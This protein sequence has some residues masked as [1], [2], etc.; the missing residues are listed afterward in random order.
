VT[1]DFTATPTVGVVTPAAGTGPPP[2]GPAA[3]APGEL[4]AGR[5]RIARLLGA[6]GAGQVFEAIDLEIDQPLALKVLHPRFAGDDR[7]T[8]HFK[9]EFLLARR[10]THPNV[11]RVFDLFTHRP[12]APG[13]WGE[14]VVFLTMELLAGETLASRLH[15]RGRLAPEEV[16]PL[17]EQVAR[18]LDAAHAAGV[19]HRDFKSA[20]VMLIPAA[21]EPRAV[22]TDFGVAVARPGDPLWVHGNRGM[23]GSPA[24]MAPEQVLGAEVTAAADI[25]A[26]GVVLYELVTGRRPFGGPDR[27]AAALQRLT[28]PPMPPRRLLPE[29]DRRWEE[30]ILR[31]LEREPASRF[32]SAGEAIA[33]L[34]ADDPQRAA[35]V[36]RP[37]LAVPGLD[38]LAPRPETGWLAAAL[39]TS[40]ASLPATPEAARL[41]A[42]GLEAL[43]R[44]EAAAARDLLEQAVALDPNFPLAHMALS[45]AWSAVGCDATA[46]QAASRA[47]ELAVRL[48]REQRLLVEARYWEAM[49]GWERAAE[50]YRALATFFPDEPAY[51]LR[52]AAVQTQNGRA[53]DALA[54][55]DGLRALAAPA[56]DD[57]RIDL[58]EARAAEALSEFGRQL[59]AAETAMAKARALGLPLLEAAAHLL[60]GEARQHSGDL[61]GALTA[62][63]AAERI[64]RAAGDLRGTAQAVRL[65]G[66]VLYERRDLAGAA[67]RHEEGLALARRIGNRKAIGDALNKIG[68]VRLLQGRF[69]EA[70]RTYEEALAIRREIADLRGIANLE[71]N[72]GLIHHYRSDLRGARPWYEA[73]LA[74]FTRCGDR[75]E[76]GRVLY[77]LAD[78]LHN[79]G[80]LLAARAV[81]EQAL[82]LFWLIGETGERKRVV[83]LIASGLFEGGDLRRAAHLLDLAQ[84]LPDLGGPLVATAVLHLR[85]RLLFAADELAAARAQ[86]ELL[87]REAAAAGDLWA[88]R[89]L[90]L[91]RLCVDFEDGRNHEAE[92]RASALAEYFA[93]LGVSDS[94]AMAL[95][96]M[97]ACRLTAGDLAAAQDL[98]ARAARLPMHNLLGR[99]TCDIFGA[100][101]AARAGGQAA[102]RATLRGIV[103]E[104]RRR[105]LVRLQ[106]RAELATGRLLLAHGRPAQATALLVRLERRSRGLGFHLFARRAAEARANPRALAAYGV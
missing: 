58:E 9:R 96:V 35:P 42:E 83:W 62:F 53:G 31:C 20:N 98:T 70:R 94:Q 60:A 64:C 63:A 67:E 8:T 45:E 10:I 11:C 47:L 24:Y 32:A 16:L 48:P 79:E 37:T 28:R 102:A 49:S 15:R 90:S 43:R 61:D 81:A 78:L 27:L 22:I 54:T 36:R 14:A 1:E 85:A 6:G 82:S 17:L 91:L 33:A 87:D 13:A 4:A 50:V 26:L 69:E 75:R 65:T 97:A 57:P 99:F 3:F 12:A 80:N 89:E 66:A 40:P 51:A 23:V 25:Y 7:A 93:R 52:L 30:T 29:L 46:Q 2:P 55:L 95:T 71:S 68:N 59:V 38:D 76:R 19:V 103:A 86:L 34:T 106:L 88:R 18:A 44:C 41:Y 104:T 74:L 5:F 100:E 84:A 56:G 101:V 92:E 72:L 105:G 77:K 21:G 73:A 39:A